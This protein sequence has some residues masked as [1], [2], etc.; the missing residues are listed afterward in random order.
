MG[1]I[2]C[3]LRQRSNANPP[4]ALR[5]AGSCGIPAPH[6]GSVTRVSR[7][8]FSLIEILMVIVLMGIM[9]GIGF[10]RMRDALVKSD[11]KSARAE[12]M[13]LY[14]RGRASAQESGR[15][16]TLDFTGN[17]ALLT[18]SPRLLAGAGT[19]DT[20]AGPI[21]LVATYKVTAAGNPAPT[22]TIDPRGFGTSA[23]T[24]I[25]FARSG[26]SDSIVVSNFGRIIH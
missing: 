7:A 22:L 15:T 12:A 25:T 19:I 4:T 13:L 3:Q 23:G 6:G 8:G 2:P 10:P 14:A 17:R 9:A 20:L 16:V 5:P 11:V 24:T 1:H 26:Y 21:N 18:A